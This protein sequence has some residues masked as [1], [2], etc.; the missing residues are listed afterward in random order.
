MATH[1]FYIAAQYALGLGKHLTRRKKKTQVKLLSTM[2]G[3]K[4][5]REEWYCAERG[6]PFA[7]LQPGEI[8][9]RRY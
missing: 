8:S 7:R 9:V 2:R 1:L 3:R 6:R 5:S 4:E